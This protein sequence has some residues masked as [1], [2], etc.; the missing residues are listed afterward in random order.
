MPPPMTGCGS[1]GITTVAF[2]LDSIAQFAR[3]TRLLGRLT[4]DS[5]TRGGR[6][7]TRSWGRSP[8]VRAATASLPHPTV[9]Y[10]TWDKPIIAI[11]GGSFLSELLD[12][13]GARTSTRSVEAPSATVALED[14]VQRNPDWCLPGH[15]AD[16]RCVR[17]RCG[18]PFR[19]CATATC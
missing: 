6:S 4:G 15:R 10:P 18:A 11:G 12:I 3:D 1:A 9:F 8:R 5:A 13:A 17:A 16:R 7:S 14:V 19:R 2:K